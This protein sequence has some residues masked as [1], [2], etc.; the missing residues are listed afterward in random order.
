[1]SLLPLI[2]VMIFRVWL[3][4]GALGVLVTAVFAVA[5]V[6]GI[7]VSQRR[8]RTVRRE[9][10]SRG[11]DFEAPAMLRLEQLLASPRFGAAVDN[12]AVRLRRRGHG[13]VGGRVSV[14]QEG[15]VWSPDKLSKRRGIAALR[16][17]WTDVDDVELV[18]MVGVGGGVGLELHLT[19]DAQ[20][21]I[22]TA[23]AAALRAAL[24]RCFRGQVR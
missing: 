19:G 3:G 8:G 17:P 5:L 9:V 18:P 2:L 11:G 7:A 6:G 13:E 10:V 21:S 22:H 24:D 4:G 15:V 20:L 23:D 14:H 12:L 1:M 16:V